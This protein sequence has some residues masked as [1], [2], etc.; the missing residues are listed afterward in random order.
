MSLNRLHLNL[1]VS[2]IFAREKSDGSLRII[3]NLTVLSE[4]VSYRHIKMNTS[5]TAI[6]LMSKSRY[7][8]SFDWKDVF[9][10]VP[11]ATDYRY[12]LTFAWAG[13]FYQYPC[14][15][16]GL[17]CAPR[18]LT[19][20]SKLLF[21]ELGKKFFISTNYIDDFLLFANTKR[22]VWSTYRALF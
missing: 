5:Q 21:S 4:N 9:Y 19:K 2:N 7:M 20:L 15:P 12:I 1:Y 8:A 16:N 14:L 3:L 6:N 13:K 18:Y 17:A 22:N 10:S 11:V